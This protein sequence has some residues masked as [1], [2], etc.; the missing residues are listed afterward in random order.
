MLLCNDVKII[1]HFFAL[2]FF[3]NVMHHLVPILT[4]SIGV[5]RFNEYIY[6]ILFF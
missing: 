3:S 2:D 4:L 5:N 6:I 1:F